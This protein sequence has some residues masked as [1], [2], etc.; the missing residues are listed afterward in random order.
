MTTATHKPLG[1]HPGSAF[2]RIP[3]ASATVGG[4]R[5]AGIFPGEETAMASSALA[6]PGTKYGPCASPCQHV[7]CRTAREI[8]ESQCLL[9]GDPIGF[10]R[11]FYNYEGAEGEGFVHAAC[12]EDAVA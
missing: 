10:D 8:A 7:D 9:C 12:Y 4:R 1:V 11:H 3:S 5:G 6:A 2:I